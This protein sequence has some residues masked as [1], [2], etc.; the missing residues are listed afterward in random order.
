[1]PPGHGLNLFYSYSNKDEPLRGGLESHLTALQRQNLL[2]TW[3]Y[4]DICAGEDWRRTIDRRL[5][6]ADIILL[7]VSADFI[8][9]DYCW[10]VE[11][12]TALDRHRQRKA[13]VVPV[14]L[15]PCDWQSARFARLQA[16]PEGAKPVVNWRSRDHAWTNVATSI[17]RLVE[18][19]LRSRKKP[20]SAAVALANHLS[21]R[22]QK[23][24]GVLARGPKAFWSTVRSTFR[25]IDQRVA[26][27][28]ATAPNLRIKSSNMTID[29]SVH[30]DQ[31]MLHVFGR[32][33]DPL[34][35]S[36]LIV[37]IIT[38]DD[39]DFA[40]SC[41]RSQYRF[42]IADDG[43]TGWTKTSRTDWRTAGPT[44]RFLAPEEVAE[45][46]LAELLESCDW[47]DRARM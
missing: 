19:R 9:S 7:L 33:N 32:L 40:F 45:E 42:S 16:L 12:K 5:L 30:L 29:C 14:I 36:G 17:R 37:K 1:M 11:M 15:K 13:I 25:E 6:A 23:V 28:A 24:N 35:Q 18:E 39:L 22:R 8:A 43:T 2:S 47:Q 10:K 31:T 27:I 3:S 20:E 4:R 38:P 46:C 21:V 26:A 41:V 44:D 34:N